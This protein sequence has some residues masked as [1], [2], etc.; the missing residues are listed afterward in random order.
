MHTGVCYV[1]VLVELVQLGSLSKHVDQ[2]TVVE[3][4]LALVRRRQL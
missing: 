3:L 1:L 2:R 4:E